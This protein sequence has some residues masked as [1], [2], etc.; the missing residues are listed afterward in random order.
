MTKNIESLPKKLN[1]IEFKEDL[2]KRSFY[3]LYIEAIG[4]GYILR[5]LKEVLE[6]LLFIYLHFSLYT[7]ISNY[8]EG[9]GCI[10]LNVVLIVNKN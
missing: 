3:L 7:F 8:K 9:Y 2:E 4:R 10:N 5:Y 6:T 1:Q